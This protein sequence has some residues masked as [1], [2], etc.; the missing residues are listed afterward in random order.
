MKSYNEF[1]SSMFQKN[2]KKNSSVAIKELRNRLSVI[3]YNGMR[4]LMM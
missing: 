2:S 1:F 3:V 4:R